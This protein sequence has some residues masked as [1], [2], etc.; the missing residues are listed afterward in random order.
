MND[1]DTQTVVEANALIQAVAKMDTAPLKLFEIAVS[2]LDSKSEDTATTVKIS[3]NAI[4]KALGYQGTTR[5]AWLTAILTKLQRDAVFSFTTADTDIS[6]APV[7]KIV[8]THSSQYVEIRFFSE[9]M[10]YIS[11]LKKS[12]TQYQLADVLKLTSRYAIVLYRWLMMSW[13]QYEHYFGTK[14]RTP[15][16]LVDYQNPRASLD[17]LHRLTGTT[18]KYG[19]FRNFRKSVLDMAV[20]E[21]TTKTGYAITYDKLNNGRRVV[22]IVFHITDKRAPKPQPQSAVPEPAPLSALQAQ[23]TALLANPYTGLLMVAGLTD[24]VALT[25]DAEYQRDLLKRL[26]PAYD[27]FVDRFGQAALERHI[28]YVGTHTSQK[29]DKLVP[30]MLKVLNDYE[31]QLNQPQ[32]KPV[33]HA[34][35]GRS[36]ISEE[37]PEW[38]AHPENVK[39][40]KPSPEKLAKIDRMLAELEN[41]KE[42]R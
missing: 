20:D 6:I 35:S 22:G 36:Q 28:K 26:Y 23:S 38:A 42:I 31:R 12:F 2:G 34:K 8:N 29:P 19:D 41:G 14:V 25:G 10:P 11:A 39:T 7:S 1:I 16:Q 9:I 24:P 40:K 21:I 27:R 37:L 13:R 32:P 3:K 33:K 5:N 18:K 17:E 15:Q 4:F 30:Y